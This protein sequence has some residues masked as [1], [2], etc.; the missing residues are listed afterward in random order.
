MKRKSIPLGVKLAAAIHLLGLDPEDLDWHHQPP[1]AMRPIDP[2]TGET[3]PAQNDPKFIIPMARAAHKARTFGD[4]VPL[5]GDVQQIKKLRRI[6]KEAAAFR[7]RLLA[8]ASGD[9]PP[10]QKRRHSWPK[11][12][13]VRRKPI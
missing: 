4:H 3:I 9:D 7:A 12:K 1:I 6:E 2:I 13:F 11:R 5:S 8:K 10:P